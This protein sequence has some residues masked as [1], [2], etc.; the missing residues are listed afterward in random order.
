MKQAKEILSPVR[1]E[2]LRFIADFTANRGYPPSVR[3][4][5]S[6]CGF[7]TASTAQYHLRILQRA[8]YIDRKQELSR[9]ITLPGTEDTDTIVVPLLGTIAAGQPIPVPSP[10]SWTAIS[11]EQ[12][13]IPP[14]LIGNRSGVYALRVKGTSMIDALIDDGD[15]VL[16]QATPTAEDGEMVAVWLRDQQEV[17]LKRLYREQGRIRLQPANQAM[18][19]I[20]QDP[21]NVEIQGRV[22]AVVR[23]V[24]PR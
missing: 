7:R 2:I 12:V 21:G 19:P 11:E 10:D 4:I 22:I 14:D 6:A 18:Q 20:W 24:T 9:S 23:K 5:A 3:E 8:G 15:I 1:Q 13:A 17:T 16:M